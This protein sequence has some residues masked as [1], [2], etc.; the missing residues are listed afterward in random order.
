M[1]RVTV[2][3]GVRSQREGIF[4]RWE[5][6]SRREGYSLSLSERERDTLPER[7][8]YSLTERERGTHCLSEGGILSVCQWGGY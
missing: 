1:L 2:G 4:S 3:E 8:R 7:G 6:L 5:I